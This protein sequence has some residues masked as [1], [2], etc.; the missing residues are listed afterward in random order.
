MRSCLEGHLVSDDS[1]THARIYLVL[2]VP[3]KAGEV[4]LQGNHTHW[5]RSM[6]VG[7]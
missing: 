1:R 7:P 4:E 2:N 5:L 6:W 3:L